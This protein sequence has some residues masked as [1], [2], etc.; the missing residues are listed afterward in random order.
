VCMIP[1]QLLG[2]QRYMCSEFARKL[3]LLSYSSF[4]VT[5]CVVDFWATFLLQHCALSS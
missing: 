4:T 2:A 1:D 3:R 5:H